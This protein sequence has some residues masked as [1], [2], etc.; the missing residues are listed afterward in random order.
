M[1]PL[2]S[3]THAFVILHIDSTKMILIG[4]FLMEDLSIFFTYLKPAQQT[5]VMELRNHRQAQLLSQMTFRLHL[6][7]Q[8]H[9][10]RV[11]WE[12]MHTHLLKCH[13]L[14]P[15]LL[16]ISAQILLASLL[17]VT[18]IRL[19]NLCLCIL[20]ILQIIMSCSLPF[21]TPHLL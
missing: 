14:P 19:L 3:F 15:H 8:L 16:L 2:I 7:K 9:H 11:M 21:R 1:N 17:V 10:R 4:N 18:W 12:N 6:I 20:L 13:I 5:S